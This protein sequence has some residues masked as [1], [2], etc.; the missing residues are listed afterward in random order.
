MLK[1]IKEEEATKPLIFGDVPTNA[2]FESVGGTLCQKLTGVEAHVIADGSGD[3]YCARIHNWAYTTPIVKIIE[4]EK[5]SW[6]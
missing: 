3:L 6:K 4:T 5:L 1:L 2:L